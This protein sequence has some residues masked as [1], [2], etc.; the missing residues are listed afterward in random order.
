[1][2]VNHETTLGSLFDGIGGFPYAGLFY[3]I[4]PLWASEILPQAV[5]L[6]QR[7]LP[8]MEHVG[9]ITQLDGAKLPPVDIITFG[10]PCQGLSTAGRRLGLADERSALFS[11]AVRIINEM[12]EATDG[13]YPR[14]A[15]WENVP[16]ALSSADGLD[17]KA[18]LEAFAKTEVPIPRSGRWANAGMVR[19]GG[20]DLAWRVLNAQKCEAS[21]FWANV[22]LK[23]MLSHLLKMR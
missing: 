16:G 11:E 3:G 2:I 19:S 5:S 12:R 13:K 22:K 18:V 23:I 1:M 21:H 10:S 20:I 14:F 4:R 17:F 9:D 7:H 6:T 15:L 8:R